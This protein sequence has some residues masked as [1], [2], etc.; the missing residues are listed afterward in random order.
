MGGTWQ[1]D[2]CTHHLSLPRNVSGLW[3][4]KKR[5][6]E[7]VLT[8]RNA[9]SIRQ[10]RLLMICRGSMDSVAIV[11]RFVN[12][13]RILQDLEGVELHL[14]WLLDGSYLRDPARR[15][16]VKSIRQEWNFPNV[17]LYSLPLSRFGK[18]GQIVSAAFRVLFLARYVFRHRIGIVLVHCID[19]VPGMVFK[20]RRPFG[21][22]CLFDMQGAV[23]EEVAYLGARASIVQ[24]LEARERKTLRA[25]ASA[26]C[27]SRKMVEH[28]VQ[29]YGTAED[30]LQVVPCCV[31]SVLVGEHLELRHEM[32]RNLGLENKLVLVYSG[33]TDRYQCVSEM[34]ALFA[35]LANQR[36][37][38]FWLILSWGDHGIFR[39]NLIQQGLDPQQFSLKSVRQNE[40]HDH[41]LAADVGLLLRE[42]HVLNRVSSPTKFAEYLAAGVPVITTP[43]VGDVSGAVVQEN[44]GSIV[45]LPLSADLDGL[46]MFLDS[47]QRQRNAF[48]RR[49]LEF[50]E[51]DWTWESRVSQFLQA[52]DTAGK[53]GFKCD[54]PRAAAI[55]N[56][57]LR[58]VQGLQGKKSSD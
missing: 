28:V 18:F 6:L 15:Q 25:C 22:Q 53:H 40:V 26:F 2:K 49:C 48:A 21:V 41:L 7:A 33:G 11:T 52:I 30:K 56:P 43:Y 20:L 31:S 4:S 34:C 32:R 44:I 35:N 58:D 3:K 36:D 14:V 10:K 46:M 55:S 29:K 23:P 54:T 51:R 50:V 42:D 38:V 17:V 19:G 57:F 27:V 8:E 24:R 13:A 47:V 9:G 16:W 12:Q 1:V 5:I 45:D 39:R 37:D